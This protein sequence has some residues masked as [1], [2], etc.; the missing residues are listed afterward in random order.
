MAASGRRID[1]RFRPAKCVERRLLCELFRAVVETKAPDTYCY[2]GF[3]SFY[4]EDF[5]MVH[6]ELGISRMVSI[7]ADVYNKRRYV[8]NRPFR[9]VDV[10]PGKSTAVLPLLEWARPMILWL[11]YEAPLMEYIL[12]DVAYAT[13]RAAKGSVLVVSVNAETPQVVAK[14]GQEANDARFEEIRSQMGGNYLPERRREETL[15]GWGVADLYTGVLDG[16]VQN[17][18]VER[19]AGKGLEGLA[20]AFRIANFRYKDGAKML[21]GGWFI[22]DVGM[23]EGELR[24]LFGCCTAL[25]LAGEGAYEIE[26]PNLTG[27]E[28]QYLNQRLP[29]AS[30]KLPR[31]PGV[32]AEDVARYVELYRYYPRYAQVVN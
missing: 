27:N 24:S 9:C 2:A 20:S 3:G 7:E 19:N 21:T 4:F 31:L 29:C 28:V 14:D 17:A 1:Y 32:P 22:G 26:V 25:R 13:Q 6:R 8:F 15:A 5:I 16:L 10:K 12:S 30:G 23:A 18:V 11:D